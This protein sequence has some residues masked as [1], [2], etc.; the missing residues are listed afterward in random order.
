VKY[1]LPFHD[2]HYDNDSQDFRDML[3]PD[4]PNEYIKVYTDK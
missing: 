4:A 3:I 1:R 2:K